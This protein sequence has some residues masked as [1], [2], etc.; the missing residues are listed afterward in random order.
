MAIQDPTPVLDQVIWDMEVPVRML[1]RARELPKCVP[2]TKK[3][4][5][6]SRVIID[7]AS[8]ATRRTVVRALGNKSHV[9][10]LLLRA[11]CV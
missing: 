2:S 11:I 3:R 10:R 4:N 1:A 9:R 7:V 6:T 5:C 8:L